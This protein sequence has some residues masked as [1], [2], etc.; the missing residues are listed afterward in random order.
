[1]LSLTRGQAVVI[2][3][4]FSASGCQI[5]LNVPLTPRLPVILEKLGK[6]ETRHS[7]RERDKSLRA[8]HKVYHGQ[9]YFRNFSNFSH[10][11]D[12]CKPAFNNIK[13]FSFEFSP[14][15]PCFH[16]T[17]AIEAKRVLRKHF[18]SSNSLQHLFRDDNN[19]IPQTLQP[20]IALYLDFHITSA[21]SAIHF[22]TVSVFPCVL[23]H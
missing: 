5:S 1:M 6:S 13:V 15:S 22:L 18:A 21:V 19:N 4:K 11:N 20:M 3:P 2:W 14:R 17:A 16:F 7:K 9:S 10:E 23:I 8:G 12:L